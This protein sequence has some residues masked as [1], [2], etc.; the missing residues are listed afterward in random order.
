MSEIKRKVIAFTRRVQQARWER[1]ADAY[2]RHF[3]NPHQEV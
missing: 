2:W 3:T 1:Q